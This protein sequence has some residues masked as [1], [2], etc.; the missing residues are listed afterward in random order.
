MLS[1]FINEDYKSWDLINNSEY[2]LMIIKDACKLDLYNIKI[3]EFS[4]I[5]NRNEL[6]YF[7]TNLDFCP[8]LEKFISRMATNFAMVANSNTY[9]IKLEHI[10][11]SA[12]KAF[13]DDKLD[14]RLICTL[15][16]PGGT[17]WADTKN[18]NY[19]YLNKHFHSAEEKNSKLIKGL[20]Q[21][22]TSDIGDVLLMKGSASNA[23]YSLVHR[24][25]PLEQGEDRWVFTISEQF[26]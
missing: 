23:Q 15:Y 8:L 14:K 5:W 26:K 6:N 1:Y 4:M 7:K 9:I 20:S 25:Y 11:N 19:E 10:K 12:C 13:H 18:V 22:N 24:S 21:I 2:N 3:H 16:G 17:Q